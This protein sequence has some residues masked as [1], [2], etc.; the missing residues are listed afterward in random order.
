MSRTTKLEGRHVLLSYCHLGPPNGFR[1]SWIIT[2]GGE[3]D[4]RLLECFDGD[5]ITAQIGAGMVHALACRVRPNLQTRTR[6]R[7]QTGCKLSQ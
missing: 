2:G 5:D 4:I 1:T 7:R 3:G 6:P